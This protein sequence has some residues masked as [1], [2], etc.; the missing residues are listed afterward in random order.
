[1]SIAIVA[2]PLAGRGRGRK[3]A[4]VVEQLLT[5]DNVD[6]EMFFTQHP[7]HAIELAAQACRKHPVVAALGG[8]GTVREVLSAIWD[9]PAALGV[10]PGGTGNDYARGLGIPRDTREALKVLREGF[11][12]PLDVGLEHERPF[13]QL[14]CIGFPVDVICHVNEHRD[15]LIKGSAAFLV[16]LVATLRALRHYPVRIT[17]DGKTME[18]DVV[19]VFVMNMPYGGG[20]MKFAPDVRYD[21]GEFHVVIVENLSKW[22]L[23]LTLPKIYSGN[24]V[25]HRAVSIVAGKEVRI[26][27]QSLP[28]MLDGDIFPARPIHA[29]IQPRAARV[30][31]PKTPA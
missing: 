4:R 25:G 8:D 21:G 16:S 9:K 1:M 10:I 3:V 13:G 2:N 29:K 11:T 22:D 23:A 7:E 12:A 6:F 31:I 28:V 17:L 26:E 19:G 27:G 15:G 5:E 30:V 18:K 14:A 20:G 24:H